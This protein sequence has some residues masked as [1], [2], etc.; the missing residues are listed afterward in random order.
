MLITY[1][2]QGITSQTSSYRLRATPSRRSLRIG[3]TQADQHHLREREEYRGEA[4]TP[5]QH[6][7]DVECPHSSAN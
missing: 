6:C 3:R 7:C 5:T 1:T 4:T 2:N